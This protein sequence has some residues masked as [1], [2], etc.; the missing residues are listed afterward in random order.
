[1][2][3]ADNVLF[4]RKVGNL[5]Q[6]IATVPNSPVSDVKFHLYRKDI[7]DYDG[8]PYVPGVHL[9]VNDIP[10][11]ELL[12][13]SATQSWSNTFEFAQ[14]VTA[15]HFKYYLDLNNDGIINVLD[16]NIANQLGNPNM[17]KIEVDPNGFNSFEVTPWVTYLNTETLPDGL[18]EFRAVPID[19][20]R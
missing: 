3:R 1:M 20:R 10:K 2:S 14:S 6:D 4:Q 18:Y 5:W 7:P 9:Y 8:L 19:S 11:G 12:W 13:D 16:E 17:Y 15:Y